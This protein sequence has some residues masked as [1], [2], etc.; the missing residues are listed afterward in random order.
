MQK[1]NL[2]F[3]FITNGDNSITE[4]EDGNIYIFININKPNDSISFI[5]GNILHDENVKD[6]HVEYHTI[7][8]SIKEEDMVS[9]SDIIDSI[10]TDIFGIK[11]T[12]D[13]IV[14]DNTDANETYENDTTIDEFLMDINDDH[15]NEVLK[16]DDQS[17]DTLDIIIITECDSNELH[18]TNDK[19]IF[20]YCDSSI[21]SQIGILRHQLGLAISEFINLENDEVE[22]THVHVTIQVK[23]HAP[24]STLVFVN[25]MKLMISEL[26]DFVMIRK[27]LMQK[28]TDMDEPRK[29]NKVVIPLFKVINSHGE[30]PSKSHDIFSSL[31]NEFSDKSESNCNAGLFSSEYTSD[32]YMD[33][34]KKK[35]KKK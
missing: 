28:T 14:S 13:V 29:F 4:N 32:V 33:K 34:K 8:D 6:I 22:W 21:N 5:K 16:N 19:K 15:H 10:I 12:G 24:L 18:T 2:I 1:L 27:N 26:I 30:C 25:T 35:K 9:V 17:N 31:L 3:S 7:D 11:V 20:V 23:D